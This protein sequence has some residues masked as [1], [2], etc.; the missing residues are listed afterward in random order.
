MSTTISE[1]MPKKSSV[2]QANRSERAYVWVWL[3]GVTEPVVAGVLNPV[4]NLLGFTYGTSYLKRHN[5]IPL[6]LPE[7]PLKRGTIQPLNGLEVAGAIRDAGPDAWGQRVILA[8]RTGKLTATSDTG[9]L[10]LLTY[11]LESGSNRIGG[12]DF[13]ISPTEYVPRVTGATLSEMQSTADMFLAGEDFPPELGAAFLHG[14]SIG[15]ARPKVLLTESKHGKS[16]RELIAKLSVVSDPYPVVKAEAVAMELARRVGLNAAHTRL[17]ESLNRDVLLIE[18]FDRPGTVGSIPGML[19]ERRLVVSALTL[20]GLDEMRGR[21]ATYPDLADIIRKRFTNPANTLREL[22]SRIVFSICIGNTDDHARNH[23]AFWD[24]TM[25]TLTPAYDLCP[26]LRSGE[27]AD[28]A[29]AIGRNGQRASRLSVALDAAEIYQLTRAQAQA[30][31]DHQVSVITNEWNT[32][33]DLAKLT[34]VERA[35]L[36]GRQILNPSIHYPH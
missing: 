15:G 33:A 7:L 31:I 11:L 5:A 21:Y 16:D 18:R 20:L 24:G 34:T 32:A 29:M 4:G 35:Q 26:Q 14:S 25:L 36:W 8:H 1:F 9:D 23:A 2:P 6:Y 12:L 28:Q 17:T 10:P 13:Q 3:P 27:T 30:I 19:G 22:F